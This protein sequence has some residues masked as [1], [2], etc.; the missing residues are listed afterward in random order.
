MSYSEKSYLIGSTISTESF[1]SFMND[2]KEAFVSMG[3]TY[4]SD[5]S[6]QYSS[7]FILNKSK[8]TYKNNEIKITIGLSDSAIKSIS[9]SQSNSEYR[10]LNYKVSI[11]NFY[12]S[13]NNLIEQMGTDNQYA[14]SSLTS[15]LARYLTIVE[16]NTG[17]LYSL[18][19]L[20]Y[21]IDRPSYMCGMSATQSNG[22]QFQS[23][24]YLSFANNSYLD[25]VSIGN[26]VYD[27]NL[28]TKSFGTPFIKNCNCKKLLTSPIWVYSSQS[29]YLI[30]GY[31][32]GL[33]AT[34]TIDVNCDYTVNG[35]KY[36]PMS[37]SILTLK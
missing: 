29:P 5:N 36:T 1:S 4:D 13:S 15:P 11:G 26:T 30:T 16:R 31:V 33:L 28:C 17:S 27:N 24:K 22:F 35:T 23:F 34:S 7:I 32:Q 12:T 25:A 14:A 18:D 3:H 9:S 20:P 2:I 10:Y 21:I 8:C 37:T 6:T 19:F